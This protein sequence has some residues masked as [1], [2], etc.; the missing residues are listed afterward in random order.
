[1]CVG[2]AMNR[3]VKRIAATLAE[4]DNVRALT[5]RRIEGPYRAALEQSKPSAESPGER[6]GERGT[7]SRDKSIA[8]GANRAVNPS[9][10]HARHRA[11]SHEPVS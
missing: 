6:P 7:Q 1:M 11:G 3:F 4:L 5:L 8:T 9:V 2:W 10:V